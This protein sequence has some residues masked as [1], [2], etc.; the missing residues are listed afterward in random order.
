[1]HESLYNLIITYSI[2]KDPSR[3]KNNKE[4]RKLDCLVVMKTKTKLL[5][6]F[7]GTLIQCVLCDMFTC[8]TF[9]V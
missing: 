2:N 9:R 7:Y 4:A 8:V 5:G 6:S 1:M 3:I